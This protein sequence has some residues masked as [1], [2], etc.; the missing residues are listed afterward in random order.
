MYLNCNFSSQKSRCYVELL[1][2]EQIFD[3]IFIENEKGHRNDKN[4]SCSSVGKIDVATPNKK[5]RSIVKSVWRSFSTWLVGF[6]SEGAQNSGVLSS[7]SQPKSR[8]PI[9]WPT[10]KSKSN[11]KWCNSIRISAD[12]VYKKSSST[13]K[14]CADNSAHLFFIRVELKNLTFT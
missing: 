10:Q 4:K 8:V 3:I 1:T 6:E 11:S 9:K 7:K 14:G 12:W 2:Q 5:V 13:S